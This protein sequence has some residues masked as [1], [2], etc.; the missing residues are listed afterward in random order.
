MFCRNACDQYDSYWLSSFLEDV[1]WNA[2]FVYSSCRGLVR[3]GS[4]PC[5]CL[6]PNVFDQRSCVL[7]PYS[8]HLVLCEGKTRVRSHWLDGAEAVK[9]TLPGCLSRMGRLSR[10]ANS[11]YLALPAVSPPRQGGCNRG[12]ESRI[13]LSGPNN[14][15]FARLYSAQAGQAISLKQADPICTNSD[16]TSRRNTDG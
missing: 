16:G 3:A 11:A 5:V 2:G 15:I 9:L 7:R 6:Y 10:G 4:D 12:R 13:R 14:T 1:C 8:M